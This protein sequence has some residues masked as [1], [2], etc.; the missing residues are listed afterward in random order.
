MGMTLMR[1]MSRQNIYAEGDRSVHVKRYKAGKKWMQASLSQIDL[2][3][4]G[5]QAEVTPGEPDEHYVDF[6]KGLV[7]AVA[8]LG[9]VAGAVA[10]V[11]A[12]MLSRQNKR[13]PLIVPW[14][15]IIQ[16]P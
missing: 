2:I 5:G 9:G 13:K 6:V 10:P 12:E 14:R 15:L 8:T 16:L 1:K 11:M 4:L 7:T 3:K